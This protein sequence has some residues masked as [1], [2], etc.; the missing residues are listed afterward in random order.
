[1]VMV[2]VEDLVDNLLHVGILFTVL[3]LFFKMYIGKV[4]T[5]AFQTEFKHLIDQKLGT[6][7]SL[8]R[9]MHSAVG[10]RAIQSKSFKALEAKYARPEGGVRENNKWLF[11]C[12]FMASLGMAGMIACLL[13]AS[14]THVPFLALLGHNAVTFAFVGVVEALFFIRVVSKYA[15]APPSLMITSA[16][17]AMKESLAS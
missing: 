12:A 10:K 7:A 9:V 15:P 4:E 3:T 16:I 11:R 2:G 6:D 13:V 5:K 14:S 8:K 1:M 17:E